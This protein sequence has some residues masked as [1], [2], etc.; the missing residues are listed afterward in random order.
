MGKEIFPVTSENVNSDICMDM[1][2]QARDGVIIIDDRNCIVFFNKAAEQLWGYT[3]AEVKGRNVKCLVPMPYRQDH[4]GFI[5]HNRETGLN[6]IVGTSREITF[7]SKNG[8]YVSAEMSISTALIGK[9]QKR[10]YMAFMKGVTEESHRRKLL[11]LQNKVFRSLSGD[12]LIQDVADLVCQGVEEFVPNTVAVLMQL[13]AEH[14]LEVLSGSGMPRRFMTALE[15]MILTEADITALANDLDEANSV[16][17]ESYRSLGISLGLHECW[18]SAIRAPNGRISGILA[19]YSRNQHKVADWPQKIVSG[20]VPFC[21]VVIEQ[22]EARQ[23]ISQLANYDPLTGFLNRSSLHKLLKSMISRPG[24]NHFAVLLLDLDRFRDINDALGHIQGDTFLKVIAERLKTLCRSNYILS[25]S[26]GDDF[27]IIIP[28]ATAETAVDFI[29]MVADAMHHPLEVGGNHLS[30]SFSTGIATFPENGPDGESLISHAE[31][32]MRQAKKEARG[33]YRLVSSIDSK[34]AQDRLVLGSAL[35]ESLSQGLLNLHYQPQIEARTGEIYGVEALARWNHPA[36]G[37]IFPSRFIAVAEETGQIEAIGRWSLEKACRQITQWDRDGVHIPVVSVNLSAGHFH[38]RSL[39]S[40]IADLLHKYDLS[41]ERL[42]VEITESVMMDESEETMN[43]LAA[44]RK[45]GV[46]LSMDDF[47]TGFSSLSRLTR[48]PLTEIKIDRSFIMNL[49]HDANAQAVTTAVIGIGN[50]LGMTVVTEGVETEVQYDLLES[51][52]CDVLQGYLFAK[53]M[54]AT[55]L[56]TWFR[57][58]RKLM[59]AMM[60]NRKKPSS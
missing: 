34:D 45:L 46:G 32:A 31:M 43:V 7:E 13:T 23:H 58:P 38:N 39:V 33:S 3:E 60:K 28:N 20:A 35:R 36:L 51:L 14:R 49:E 16:V 48:L 15:N 44:I 37:N 17:W 52:H 4:D 9:D 22:Y 11:D 6:R 41:P 19:L 5:A 50:R 2:E 1:L 47:G 24:D 53:P 57:K 12:M 8:D 21:G 30:T 27:V 40:M 10:Y 29:K 25:R 18:A 55:D 26:G 56:E 42:T 54:S 59:P